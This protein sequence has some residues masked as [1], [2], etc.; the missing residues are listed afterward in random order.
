MPPA[1]DGVRVTGSPAEAVG[2]AEVVLT[3]LLDGE[4]LLDALRQAAGALP[5]GALFLQMSTGGTNGLAPLARFADEHRLRFVD[6]P[7]WAPR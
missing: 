4:A 3:M 2:G 6:P 7:Y 5:P 1:A